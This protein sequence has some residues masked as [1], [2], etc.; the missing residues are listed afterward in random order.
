MPNGNT[1]ITILMPGR[2]IEVTPKGKVV[3]SGETTKLRMPI[4]PSTRCKVRFIKPSKDMDIQLTFRW[5]D[6]S[7]Q[8]LW[9]G[10]WDGKAEP[11]VECN[12]QPGIYRIAWDEKKHKLQGEAKF[13]VVSTAVEPQ[14]VRIELR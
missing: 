6:E 4:P 8:G 10:G 1:L 12:L 7:G 2:V 13:K 3:R 9:D 14:V 11:V 5:M